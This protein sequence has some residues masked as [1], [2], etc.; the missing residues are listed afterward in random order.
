M[1]Q[2]NNSL[3]S[4]RGVATAVRCSSSNSSNSSSSDGGGGVSGALFSDL[5]AA[6]VMFVIYQKL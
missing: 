6:V 5:Y 1:E 2:L 3:V 4:R